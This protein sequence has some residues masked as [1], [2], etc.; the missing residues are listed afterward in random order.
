MY[1][2]LTADQE[3]SLLSQ[4]VEFVLGSQNSRVPSRFQTNRMCLNQQHRAVPDG[5]AACQGKRIEKICN[6]LLLSQ[7][8][9]RRIHKVARMP[10]T[11]TFV[12]VYWQ[13]RYVVLCLGFARQMYRN[14]FE[15]H[16]PSGSAKTST[17]RTNGS[18]MWS[19]F[20]GIL[21]FQKQKKP[22]VLRVRRIV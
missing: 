14:L 3:Q 16:R 20:L 17:R 18:R 4:Y 12:R 1:G 11:L 8:E 15:H 5:M 9:S 13:I 22:I 19:M 10:S 6:W 21:F 7:S 2:I